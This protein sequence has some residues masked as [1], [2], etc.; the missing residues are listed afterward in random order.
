MHGNVWEWCSDWFGDYPSGSVTDPTGAT[1]GSDRVCRGGSWSLEAGGCRSAFRNG[2]GPGF[3]N[4][5]LGFRSV[6]SP[7]R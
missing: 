4:Y 3:R 2:V 1:S 5:S 6:L 7:S